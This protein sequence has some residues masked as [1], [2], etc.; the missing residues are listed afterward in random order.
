METSGW[1][2]QLSRGLEVEKPQMKEKSEISL[3]NEFSNK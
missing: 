3:E 1:T 2:L